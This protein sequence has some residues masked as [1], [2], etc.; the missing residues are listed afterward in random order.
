MLIVEVQRAV[1]ALLD[2]KGHFFYLSL[3]HAFLNSFLQ[4]LATNAV[5]P[6]WL[7]YSNCHNVAYLFA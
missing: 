7:E 3:N 1:I 4:Q 6:V 5:P 2:V